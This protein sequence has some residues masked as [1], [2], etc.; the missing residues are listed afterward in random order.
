M[1]FTLHKCE[2]Y[3]YG[4]YDDLLVVTVYPF[5]GEEKAAV[6]VETLVSS[7]KVSSP[8]TITYVGNANLEDGY[9]K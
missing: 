4:Y 7:C 3:I 5:A 8:I 1:P 2:K 6:G 9:K